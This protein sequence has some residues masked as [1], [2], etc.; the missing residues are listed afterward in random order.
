M[1]WSMLGTQEEFENESNE[2]QTSAE[3]MMAMAP[4]CCDIEVLQIEYSIPDTQP[5]GITPA[6]EPVDG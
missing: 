6:T 2:S 5:T 3:A 4:L 1:P